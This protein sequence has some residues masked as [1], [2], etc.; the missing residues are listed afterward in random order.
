MTVE[1]K[2]CLLKYLGYYDGRVDGIWGPVSAHAT[3]GLQDD[4][5]MEATGVFDEATAEM[6][7]KA[8]AGLVEPVPAKE[9][10]APKDFWAEIKYFKR[11]EFRCNCGGKFCD[12]FPAEPEE[13][14][15]RMADKVREHFGVAVIVSSGLRCETHNRNVGG[16]VG[17]RHKRGKAM[18]CRLN[19]ISSSMAL[20]Y[21]Q[22]QP[23]CRYA[24]AIDA[25]YVHMD[26][27]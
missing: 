19:G 13:R 11:E 6:A 20:P 8:V 5:G 18:D 12:G 2:K 22:S 21:I 15:V 25:A 4:Y 24:Y 17:S 7:K 14:L 1:Q 23:E 3:M 9:P 10:E 26:I 16:A 27:E